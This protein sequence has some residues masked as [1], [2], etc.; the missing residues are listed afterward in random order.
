[1]Q[2]GYR[3]GTY[4]AAPIYQKNANI[5]GDLGD[6]ELY[7]QLVA[8]MGYLHFVAAPRRGEFEPRP[9]NFRKKKLNC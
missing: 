5:P 2:A 4:S 9:R 3:F 7:N 6:L 1:M 8:K